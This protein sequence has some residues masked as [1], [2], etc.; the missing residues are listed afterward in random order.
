[1]TGRATVLNEGIS[2]CNAEEPT[3]SFS[4]CFLLFDEVNEIHKLVY[5]KQKNLRIIAL[6]LSLDAFSSH[7][8]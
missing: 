6:Q 2:F 7:L 8:I 5:S 3:R 1:M 4:S